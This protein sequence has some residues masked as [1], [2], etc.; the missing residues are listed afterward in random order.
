M[1][2][3]I[4]PC[5]IRIDKEGNWYH[6]GLP[7]INKK[8]YLHL[9][10]CLTRDPSGRYILSMNGEECY[11][12]VEDTPFVVQEVL[13]SPNPNNPTSLVLKLNDGT[14]ETLN[15]ETLRVGQDD[16]MY[17]T[18]KEAGYEARLLRSAYYQL[19]QFLQQE[20]ES[21]FLVLGDNKTPLANL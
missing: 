7:I 8:I 15:T 5:N 14:E 2:V 21:Y 10:Q 13:A 16:V 11:L 17:C 18:V 6:K 1:A 12:E 9:N 19:A 20:G 4:P 3:D